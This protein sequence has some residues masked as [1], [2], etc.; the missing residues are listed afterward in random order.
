[1]GEVGSA[2][3]EPA[4][5]PPCPSIRALC[6]SNCQRSTQSHQQSKGTVCPLI[7]H[8]VELVEIWIRLKIPT[9]L[10]FLTGSVCVV[11]LY[12]CNE[13]ECYKCVCN[14]DR[15]LAQN[16]YKRSFWMTGQLVLFICSQSIFPSVF[17]SIKVVHQLEVNDLLTQKQ[18]NYDMF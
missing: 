15:R 2:R 14:I 5:L 9:S 16:C 4:L 7:V 3:Y 1:M 12:I 8:E 13:E 11:D 18:R 6:Y 17:R 10:R